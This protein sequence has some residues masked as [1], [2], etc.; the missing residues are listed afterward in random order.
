MIKLLTLPE[1]RGLE[2][3]SQ[4]LELLERAITVSE[5]DKFNFLKN[6]LKKKLLLIST[7]SNAN[8]SVNDRYI[9]VAYYTVT[10]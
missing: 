4:L 7:D 8:C 6:C 1:R 9:E 3:N 5:L 2:E 10:V